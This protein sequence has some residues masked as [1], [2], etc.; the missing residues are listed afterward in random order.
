MA[1][2]RKQD[3]IYLL[4]NKKESLSGCKLPSNGD[5]LRVYLHHMGEKGMVKHEAAVQTMKE[6]E[7]FWEKARIPIRPF[8]HAVKKLEG[9]VSEWEA[10]KKNKGRRSETQE[11]NEEKFCDTL[12]DLFDIAHQDALN[13][14]KITEDKAFLEA[15]REKGRRGSMA[16][17]DMKLA[18]QEEEKSKQEER[19]L[20]RIAKQQD[21]ACQYERSVTLEDSTCSSSAGESETEGA[22]AAAGSSTPRKRTRG[23]KSILSPDVLSALDRT[24]TSDRQ[25]VHTLSAVLHA[26]GKQLDEFNVSRSSIQRARQQHRK[27][28]S[29]DLKMGFSGE[30]PLTLH[31]DG[32]LM[33]ELTGDEK[34]DRLPII[35]SG[36]GIEQLL[37]VPKLPAGTGQAMAE[38]MSEAVAD[39]GLE[40]WIRSICF[41]TTSSNTGRKNGA[42]ILFQ[43]MMGKNL[44]HL[45]CRHHIHEIM[46]EEVFLVTMGP[47][48][49]PD[50]GIFKRFKS[51]WH[52]MSMAKYNPG[53]ND[54]DVAR[55]LVNMTSNIIEFCSQQLEEVQPREDYRELLELAIIFL[56]GIPA[57]GVHFAKPGAMHR[58]RFM[59]RLIYALKIFVF[60]DVFSLT[61]RE[62]KGIKE[63]CVFGVKHYVK[64]WFC[65]RLPTAAPKSD[66]ELLKSLAAADDRAAKGALKKLSNHLWY[67]NEELVALA[68]FDTA[69]TVAEKKAM[70]AAMD[71]EGDQEPLKRVSVDL[72]AIGKK[73]LCDFVTKNTRKFFDILD[74]S[75]EFLTE[76]PSTWAHNRTYIA[77]EEIAKSLTVT[78]D[79]AE[80]GVALIQEYNGL[81]LKT[82]EQ[83]QFIMQVVREHRKLF[84]DA[85]KST[86]VEG[87]VGL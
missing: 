64:S 25:A 86:V 57:R 4:G 62:L 71:N 2:L 47:S 80:R 78:N 29:A 48:S 22:A 28:R 15:Q 24:K 8:H 51:H 61:A 16:G 23:R 7:K 40:N 63:L 53:I 18:K 11:K 81:L 27:D 70:V 41:D 26:S 76:D 43:Q 82:E 77:A 46:L 65:C 5:V 67:L 55:D 1:T 31:W 33:A 44:L 38:A 59:A 73:N 39:W 84:P 58:A 14:I 35:V 52:Q 56:G 83:T 37:C 66:L 20:R 21:E 87:L 10:L 13:M 69:V 49:G 42:C 30:K 32:K 45:A 17:V 54:A 6:V 85:R 34:V 12:N 79:T 68:F 60:R 3:D 72:L 50:I 74:L 75:Q 36:N 9:L 19:K